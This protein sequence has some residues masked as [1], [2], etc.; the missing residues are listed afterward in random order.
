M[1]QTP[2]PPPAVRFRRTFKSFGPVPAEA[3]FALIPGGC[4]VLSYRRSARTV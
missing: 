4:T 2:Y 1:T 3:A